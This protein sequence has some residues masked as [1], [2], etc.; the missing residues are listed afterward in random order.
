MAFWHLNYLF[1]VGGQLSDANTKDMFATLSPNGEA[2][3]LFVFHNCSISYLDN[4]SFSSNPFWSFFYFVL[5]PLIWF[6]MCSWHC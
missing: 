2:C 3:T 4:F 6:C 1:V 5:S